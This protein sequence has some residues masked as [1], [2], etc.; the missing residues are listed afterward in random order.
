MSKNKS[1]TLVTSVMNVTNL[2]RYP[3]KSL[4]GEELEEANIK[5]TGIEYD[6]HWMLVDDKSKFIIISLLI[7]FI[8]CAWYLLNTQPKIPGRPSKLE[9]TAA[10][11]GHFILYL[12]MITLPLSG[13]LMTS[14]EGVIKKLP[15]LGSM[16]F[17]MPGINQN[18]E[19]TI[20]ASKI[21]TLLAW[22]IIFFSCL[23]IL[24]ALKH[25]YINKDFVLRRMLPYSNKKAILMKRN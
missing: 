1:D 9:K 11:S 14:A 13:W 5:T 7:V 17:I 24:A 18:I 8:R 22:L 10:R 6:R 2:N 21:H 4:T 25:H 15:T 12:L 3:I 23:H 20:Y 16:K 19:L